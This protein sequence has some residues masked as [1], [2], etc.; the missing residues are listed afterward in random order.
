MKI[1]RLLIANRGEIACRVIKTAKSLGIHTIAVYSKADAGALHVELADEAYFIGPALAAKSYLDIE[2]IIA[3]AK[4]AHADAIHPGYGFLSENAGFAQACEKEGITFVGPPASAIRAMGLKDAAKA[5]MED[6]GVPVVPGYHGADQDPQILAAQAKLVG[7]PILIKAVAGG[8][9]KGIRLVEEESEFAEALAGATREAQ[10]SFSNP[11]VLI[12][13]FITRPRH[14]EVQVFADA[15]GNAVYLFERDCSLQRRHQKVIEEAPAPGMS[16]Q[17][18]AIMGEA[19]VK[20]AKAIGYR[21]AGTVEFIVDGSGP[22]RADGFWFMEMNTRLQVEHPV[23]EMITGLDLVAWQLR[24]A[25]GLPLPL[26]QDELGIEGHA[27]EAR[28]YA[29]DA[30]KGFMPATGRLDHLRFPPET[31]SVRIDTGVRT[32]DEISPFYDP[33]IAKIIVHGPDR[34]MALARLAAAL[35]QVEIAGLTTNL[36]FLIKLATRAEF[37]AGAVDTGFIGR[38]EGLVANAAAEPPF[39]L[40]LAAAAIA[41]GA[42]DRPGATNESDPWAAFAD[43]RIWGQAE[44]VVDL[45]WG[46]GA[47]PFHFTHAADTWRAEGSN[48]TLGL[49]ISRDAEGRLV[50]NRDGHQR[51]LTFHRTPDGVSFFDE[52]ERFSIRFGADLGGAHA[53]QGDQ[54]RILAPLPGMVSAVHVAPGSAVE[55]GRALIVVEAMKMEHTLR[56]PRDG[57]V[58]EVRVATGAQVV[59]EQVLITFKEDEDAA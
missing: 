19:A 24:I 5:V 56:A 11:S 31:G 55:K 52:G 35:K 27:F 16:D 50:L 21:G 57:H 28:L 34:E 8:G 2:K 53:E 43:F 17:V 37:I 41:R 26:T 14:I 1:K 45:D 15:H 3:T 40:K 47:T 49:K 32:G 25:Q 9:G 23:T 36:G 42:L 51:R 46:E 6:A 58:A 33:M 13:K 4:S 22:P 38:A 54:N 7:Y 10:S 20:A 12:E 30:D 29:E 18:R 39:E 44:L 59:A 48:G